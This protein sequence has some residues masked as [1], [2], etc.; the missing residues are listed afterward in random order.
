MPFIR[1]CPTPRSE[2]RLRTFIALQP[3]RP[4]RDA[5]AA[6]AKS[7]CRDT[8][9]R[10]VRAENIHLT[11]A[12]IGELERPLAVTL[13][14]ALVQAQFKPIPPW[15]LTRLGR[16]GS[17]LWCAGDALPQLLEASVSVRDLLEALQISYDKKRFAAHITLARNFRAALPAPADE[18]PEL[19]LS[20]PRLFVSE[21][22]NAGILRYRCL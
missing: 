6:F 9:A 21:R 4:Q 8:D 20:A 5:L 16:F 17:I 18:L 22:D 11:L 2:K 13:S 12:F 19:E 10:P 15:P 14:E 1:Q 3:Q 7:L